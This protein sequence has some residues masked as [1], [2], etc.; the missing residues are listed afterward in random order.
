MN[1][2]DPEALAAPGKDKQC[3]SSIHKQQVTGRWGQCTG[4]ASQISELFRG[5]DLDLEAEHPPVPGP[6]SSVSTQGHWAPRATAISTRD[7]AS[8]RWAFGLVPQHVPSG[9]L[10][11]KRQG[12]HRLFLALSLWRQPVPSLELL[13]GSF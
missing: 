6:G 2:T 7:A 9:C 3:G 11:G 5:T 1:R 4:N 13:T 12:Q 10:T 8:G